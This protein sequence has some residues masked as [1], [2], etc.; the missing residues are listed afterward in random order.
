MVMQYIHNNNKTAYFDKTPKGNELIFPVEMMASLF[1]T[2]ML[3]LRP[4]KACTYEQH[5]RL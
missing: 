4:V 1:L 2:L 5:H 3:D